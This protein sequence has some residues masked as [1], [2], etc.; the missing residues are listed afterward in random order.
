MISKIYFDAGS[1]ESKG[2]VRSRWMDKIST[3]YEWAETKENTCYQGS[4]RR[5]ECHANCRAR[6]QVFCISNSCQKIRLDFKQIKTLG[7]FFRKESLPNMYALRSSSKQPH[8]RLQVSKSLFSSLEAAK[9]IETEFMVSWIQEFII[10]LLWLRHFLQKMM[11]I[12]SELEDWEFVVLS[13]WLDLN[14]LMLSYT[15]RYVGSKITHMLNM[16]LNRLL[17]KF[18]YCMLIHH[19]WIIPVSDYIWLI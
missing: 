6:R 5:A 14:P 16:M 1:I 9:Q 4:W 7:Y 15:S 10:Y 3:R 13:W 11:R 12:K 8:C 17:N 18:L 2:A 19:N